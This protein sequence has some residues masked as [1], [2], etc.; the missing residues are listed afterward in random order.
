[1]NYQGL[2]R[3]LWAA[4]LCVLLTMVVVPVLVQAQGTTGDAKSDTTTK[5]KKH[6]RKKLTTTDSAPEPAN[7]T[8]TPAASTPE[9]N[10]PGAG[11]APAASSASN[12][13]QTA[14][15]SSSSEIAA[16]QASGKVWVNLDSGIYHKKGRWYGKTKNGK[17]MSEAE[18]K[19]A[20]Y[21]QS[22]RN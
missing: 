14:S 6:H 9:A 12:K 1:M 17:F 20:G 10:S 3:T 21:K 2:N 8:S 19:A 22:Q 5:H 7:T 15:A 16:A 13:S 11:A 4:V 18:A